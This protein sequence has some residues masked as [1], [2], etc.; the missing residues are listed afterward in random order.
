[1][2]N[3]LYENAKELVNQYNAKFVNYGIAEE[4]RTHIGFKRYFCPC[5][6]CTSLEY[7]STPSL[8]AP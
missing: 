3:A 4:S 8:D 1:M 6:C 2:S 7:D 5:P